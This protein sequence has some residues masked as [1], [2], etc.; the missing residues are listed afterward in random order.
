MLTDL[1]DPFRA[2]K[3]NPKGH[4]RLRLLHK[5]TSILTSI[6]RLTIR[7]H[8]HRRFA[9]EPFRR[10]GPLTFAAVKTAENRLRLIKGHSCMTRQQAAKSTGLKYNKQPSW[11][12]EMNMRKT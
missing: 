4:G 5:K 8:S 1:I 10:P 7:L 12:S 3:T 6:L 11:K 2:S 9:L